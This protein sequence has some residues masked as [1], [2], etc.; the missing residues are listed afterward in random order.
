LSEFERGQIVGGCLVGA[1]ETKTATLFGVCGIHESWE[2]SNISE[3]EQWAK[4]NTDRRRSSYIENDYFEKSQNYCSTADRKAELN[5]NFEDPVSPRTLR[6]ELHK[7]NLH[8]RAA[9]AKP[10]ITKSNAQMR[11]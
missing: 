1:S 11:K 3:E 6:R 10:Q 5:I 9:I 8:G 7:S 4:M 2:E